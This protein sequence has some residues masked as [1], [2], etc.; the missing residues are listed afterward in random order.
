MKKI[1]FLESSFNASILVLG[2]PQCFPD[3]FY[4]KHSLV[5]LISRQAQRVIRWQVELVARFQIND[6]FTVLD[7]QNDHKK[8]AN[9]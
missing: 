6:K 5:E 3:A 9:G 2:A 4:I 1:I 7:M 8:G